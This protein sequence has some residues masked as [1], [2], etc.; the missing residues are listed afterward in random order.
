M[1]VAVPASDYCIAGRDTSG[2]ARARL[3]GP[4]AV[5]ATTQKGEGLDHGL[6]LLA[7]A[8]GPEEGRRSA[9]VLLGLGFHD[10]HHNGA[11]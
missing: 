8:T 9:Q 1:P 2:V 10:A 4:L 3:L 6:G 11:R 7:M 5:I